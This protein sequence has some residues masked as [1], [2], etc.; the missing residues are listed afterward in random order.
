MSGRRPI[1]S[2]VALAGMPCATK[3]RD[4][5]PLDGEAAIR[6]LADQRGERIAGQ[7]DRFLVRGEVVAGFR[8]AA[9]GLLQLGARV[10]ADVDPLVDQLR[11]LAADL[12]RRF[13]RV[14][15]TIELGEV[16]I[17]RGDAG[18]QNQ[19]RLGQLIAGGFG[20]RS[21]GG[22]RRAV[23]APQVEVERQAEPGVALA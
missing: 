18:G 13:E 16:G 6:S 12:Q 7:A 10:E 8:N 23:L 21:R 1:R 3:R 14:A 17:G 19:P 9:F 2:I 4:A 15:L 22:Q 11:G 5:R 20:V